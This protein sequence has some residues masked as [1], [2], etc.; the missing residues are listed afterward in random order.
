[1][2][3]YSQTTDFSAKDALT[4]GNPSKA[5]KGSELDVEF[6]AI[7]TA[8]LSKFDSTDLATQAEAE[9]GAVNTKLMTP[10]RVSQEIAALVS[11]QSL[12]K[13]AAETVNNSSTLQD[14]NHLTGFTIEASGVYRVFGVLVLSIKGASDFKVAVTLG[15]APTSLSIQ[16]SGTGDNAAARA[17]QTVSGTGVALTDTVDETMVVVFEGL[18]VNDTDATTAKLQ[19]AQNSAQSED[20][21]LGIGSFMTLDRI[22]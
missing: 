9:G 22:G 12:Y 14:D 11:T 20:T 3:D 18:I 17:V 10:L 2:T 8:I 16:F 13:T 21:I 5:I 7:S 1:M 15:S 6:A 4:T 19:W